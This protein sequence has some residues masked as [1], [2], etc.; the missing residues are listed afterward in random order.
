MGKGIEM[1]TWLS[2]GAYIA[3]GLIALV[4]LSIAAALAWQ[5]LRRAPQGEADRRKFFDPNATGGYYRNAGA[6]AMTLPSLHAAHAFP[7]TTLARF[8][9][10]DGFDEAG[11]LATARAR[12]AQMQAAWDSGDVQ[13]I[14]RYTTPDLYGELLRQVKSRSGVDKTDVVALDAQLLGIQQFEDDYLASVEFS[15]IVREQ[16]FG[17]SAPFREVWNLSRKVSGGEWQLAG[18]EQLGA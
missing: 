14:E 17:G 1:M 2:G 8:G 18:V 5:R 15:G 16:G 10:P 4:A 11:L 6:E 3:V 7:A 12:F 13:T 9:V